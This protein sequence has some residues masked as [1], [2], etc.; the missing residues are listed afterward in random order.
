MLD[1]I[2]GNNVARKKLI[3]GYANDDNSGATLAGPSNAVHT[4]TITSGKSTS[5]E[6][7]PTINQ[8]GTAG[9]TGLQVNVIETSTGSGAKTLADFMVNGVSR[10]KVS[11]TGQLTIADGTQAAGRILT[12]D[13]S[14]NASW[15]INT[16]GPA[17]P[18]ANVTSPGATYDITTAMFPSLRTIMLSANI[19][20]SLSA[21][22]ASNLGGTITLILKQPASGGPYTVTWP[23]SLEW[24]GDA[25]G[26]SMPTTA[27]AELIIHLLWTGS[28][29]R[30]INA[31]S[32]FP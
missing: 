9:Y 23:A 25:T 14:G 5:F 32:F 18:A 24:A 8:S 12:S 4:T 30:G 31:G 20:I 29:W 6:I 26:P 16:A 28:V 2:T 21:T 1:A 7:N 22:P 17:G 19:T 10:L 27:N 3:I 13:A 15:Q 11:N